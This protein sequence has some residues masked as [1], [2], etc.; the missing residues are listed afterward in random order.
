MNL[1][2]VRVDEASGTAQGAPEPLTTP[3]PWMG[4]M[5]MSRDGRRIAYT[6][7]T[8]ITSLFRSEFDPTRERIARPPIQIPLGTRRTTRPDVSPDGK[9]LVAEIVQGAGREDLIVMGTDGTGSF[10]LTNDSHRDRAPKWS[11]DGQRIAF[12]SDRSGTFQI[13][14]IN[15]DGSGLRQV[16]DAEV[17]VT[18][19]IWGPKGARMVVRTPATTTTPA[20]AFVIDAD[21]PWSEQTLDPLPNSLPAINPT[22]WSPDGRKLTLFTNSI[23]TYVG[24]TYVYDFEARQVERVWRTG[25]PRW[26]SDSRRLLVQG[27]GALHLVDTVTGKSQEVKKVEGPGY[28]FSSVSLSADNRVIVYGLSRHTS[29]IWLASA[30]DRPATPRK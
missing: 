23:G 15:A 14:I 20:R 3:S 2:R 29:D 1:W 18:D 17:T 21:K 10:F 27:Y 19:P 9:R 26:L 11:H 16:S 6:Q 4:F 30:E 24:G 28:E 5:S 8:T 22:S 25:N 13:W 12:H 7:T